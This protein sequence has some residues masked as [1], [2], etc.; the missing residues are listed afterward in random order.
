MEEFFSKN[1]EFDP[2][3]PPPTIRQKRV[4]IFSF[5]VQVANH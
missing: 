3:H 2:P 5:W 4:R 1:L